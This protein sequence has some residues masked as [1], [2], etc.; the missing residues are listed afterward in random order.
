MNDSAHDSKADRSLRERA[1]EIFLAVVD[2]DE[3]ARA[4]AL[5]KRCGDDADLRERVEAL[6]RADAKSQGFLEPD[7]FDPSEQSSDGAGAPS[8]PMIGQVLDGFEIEERIAEGG[9]G[10]VYRARQR[11]PDRTV[12]LK[13]VR[14]A[15]ARP[16]ASRRLA[17]EAEI[18][19]KL[20]HPYVAQVLSAG[21]MP[22]PLGPVP[23]FAMEF[24]DGARSITQ[25]AKD[26]ALPLDARLGLMLDACSAVEHGH[27]RGVIHR[28]L[29]PSNVLV[30]AL[31]GVKVIDF[32]IARV[33]SDDPRQRTLATESNV[34][35]GSLPYMAPEQCSGGASSADARSD[36]YALGAIL[37]EL[38]CDVPVFDVRTK[39]LEEAL[40]AVREEQPAGLRK[41]APQVSRELEAITLQAL[42]KSPD[43]RYASAR[44]FAA[45]IHRLLEHRPVLASRPGRGRRLVLLVRRNPIA[46]AMIAMTVVALVSAATLSTIMY[47]RESKA[48][49]L[50]E[51]RRREAETVTDFMED[52]LSATDPTQSRGE[53]PTLRDFLAAASDTVENSLA[54]QPAVEA[55]LRR[56]IGTTYGNM[57]DNERAETHLR[58]SLSLAR[59]TFGEDSLEYADG[60]AALAAVLWGRSAHD[61]A[62]ALLTEALTI[63]RSRLG[64]DDDDTIDTVSALATVLS[65]AGRDSEAE[66]LLREAIAALRE[67]HPE[68]HPVL[69]RS[70]N[71]LGTIRLK[72]RAFSKAEKLIGEAMRMLERHLGSDH[73]FT[74]VT[75]M[76]YVNALQGLGRQAEALHLLDETLAEFEKLYGE[77]HFFVAICL[78][79]KAMSFQA[80]GDEQARLAAHERAQRIRQKLAAERESDRAN[81][82]SPG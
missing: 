53:E 5:A 63:R 80:L 3:D 43:D 14:Q 68:G 30:D 56:V 28:D 77:E 25:F 2:L 67:R 38:I 52:L 72:R 73:P 7:A 9:M 44:E 75:R 65:D 4:D 39:T 51:T 27:T 59:D 40:R 48:R 15:I 64:D 19:S 41:F 18:L 33:V 31:G 8:D 26:R 17:Y 49:A 70:L 24:I 37:Y 35:M 62:R 20:R 13:V 10:V 21:M 45:D 32:G 55:R 22:G 60:A 61:E 79:K 58:R 66:P 69:A 71:A 1:D 6:L 50:A 47:V 12:A 42:S 54:D 29:K 57:K 78:E 23:Y 81:G 46:S 82:E 76:N 16:D 34:V 74:N 11:Q 36:V